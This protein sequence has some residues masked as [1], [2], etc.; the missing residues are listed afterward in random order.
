METHPRRQSSPDR[1]GHLSRRALRVPHEAFEDPKRTSVSVQRPIFKAAKAEGE[2][3]PPGR[4][5][6]VRL[7]DDTVVVVRRSER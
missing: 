1:D 6:V 4:P 5:M 3:P 2:S 7:S